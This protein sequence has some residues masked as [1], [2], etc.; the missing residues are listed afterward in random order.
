MKPPQDL[1]GAI[2]KLR[3]GRLDGNI[4]PRSL[5]KIA[6]AKILAP[7]SAIQG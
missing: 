3:I 5:M 7:L 4:C 1:D 2:T 6:L